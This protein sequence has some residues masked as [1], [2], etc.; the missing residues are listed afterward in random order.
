MLAHIRQEESVD[1]A[2]SSDR[3]IFNQLAARKRQ[4][5]ARTRPQSANFRLRRGGDDDGESEGESEGGGKAA[6]PPR[7]S[8]A[9][10]AASAPQQPEKFRWS[11]RPSSATPEPEP[12]PEPAAT[13]YKF[14]RPSSATPAPDPAPKTP[15]V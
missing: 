12:E 7:P 9:L 8:S 1:T 11:R 3:S 10:P 13:P 15:F 2:A 4:S 5:M 6:L 14:R